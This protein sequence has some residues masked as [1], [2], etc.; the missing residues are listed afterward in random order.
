MHVACVDIVLS[1]EM[2]IST[3]LVIAYNNYSVLHMNNKLTKRK[4]YFNR[5]TFGHV[6]I[7]HD[8]YS[9]LHLNNKL[10]QRICFYYQYLSTTS[11]YQLK[12]IILSKERI[13]M[14]RSIF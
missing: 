2:F 11:R 13:L 5:T 14:E 3:K 1:K 10:T 7:T 6:V 8:N 4:A 12:V 9:I